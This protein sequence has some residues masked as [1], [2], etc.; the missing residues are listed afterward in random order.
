MRTIAILAVLSVAL[1]PLGAASFIT[2][3]PLLLNRFRP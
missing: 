1:M 2:I 3:K